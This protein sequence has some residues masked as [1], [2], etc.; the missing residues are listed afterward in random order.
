MVRL[1]GE[2]SGGSS[3]F[4]P[5]DLALTAD[6]VNLRRSPGIVG[7]D[8]EDVI[9]L[10]PPGRV[11]TVLNAPTEA[12]GLRWLYIGGIL[13]SG[14]DARGYVAE[15]VPGGGPLMVRAQP[16]PGTNIPDPV[17][18]SYL[19]TPFD[20][21]FG[22]SQL[23]GENPDFYRQFNYDDVALQGHNGIDFL[24][25]VGSLIFAV[26]GGEVSSTGFEPGGFGNFVL[27]RHPWGESIY[28]HLDSIGVQSGQIVGRG[29]Y[30]GR[31]GNTGG[32]T[33]PHLHFAIRVNPYERTDGWGGYSDPLPYLASQSYVLPPYVLD[34]GSLEI[35][36]S[37]PI[38]D[39]PTRELPSGMGD[40]DGKARP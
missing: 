35:F 6:Y 12:D 15:T 10:L 16:L 20:G 11:V 34:P 22:V 29:Q 27:L 3:Q 14:G 21:S 18:G 24:T 32:S 39:G 4:A 1:D 23:W 37:S 7:K 8:P 38:P 30:I 31:S 40:F 33:G 19:A 9:G 25:P 17:Q 36:P 2:P 13:Q 5:G 28:A 26:D